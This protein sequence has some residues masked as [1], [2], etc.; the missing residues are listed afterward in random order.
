MNRKQKTAIL[1]PIVLVGM[2]VPVFRVFARV[3]GSDLGWFLGLASYWILWGGLFS[4]RLIGLDE[5]KQLAKPRKLTLQ[6]F[7]LVLLMLVL[8]SLYKL[9][10]G[11]DYS[12]PSLWVTLLLLST[13][14]G[15][16]FFEEVLWRGVYMSL[17]PE[18]LL[19]RIVWPTIWFALW[20]YVPGSVHGD[21]NVLGLVIG[22]GL[23]GFYLS[24]MARKTGTIWWGIVAHTL[25]GLIMI[26]N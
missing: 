20:H 4:W 19:Y 21:G 12:K 24:F 6:A 25:G 1:A 23:M 9:I 11:M 17:F 22:S 3:F 18:N 16:G 13:T 26:L 8:A 10:P 5:I 2:M 7:L 14:L 15:N